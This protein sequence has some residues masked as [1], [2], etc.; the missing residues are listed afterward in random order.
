[1]LPVFKRESQ[2]RVAPE[3]IGCFLPIS[4][5]KSYAEP[6]RYGMDN[7]EGFYFVVLFRRDI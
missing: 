2:R 7:K 5:D 1:M 4:N 6:Q 3:A